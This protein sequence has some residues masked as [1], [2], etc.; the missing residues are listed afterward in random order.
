V[1]LDA[2]LDAPP[3][4]RTSLR[5]AQAIRAEIEAPGAVDRRVRARLKA[6][7]VTR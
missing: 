2:Y 6:V 5:I 7:A 4:P 1:A 3:E